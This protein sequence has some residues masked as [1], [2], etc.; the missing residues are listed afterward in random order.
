MSDLDRALPAHIA[1][2]TPT[3]PRSIPITAIEGLDI[4]DA[5]DIPAAPETGTHTLKSVDGVIGWVDDNA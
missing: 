5:P 1:G 4:P 3:D 2:T